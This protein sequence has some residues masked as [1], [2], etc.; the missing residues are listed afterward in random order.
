MHSRKQLANVIDEII[1]SEKEQLEEVEGT[2]V[3]D[4]KRLNDKCD[5]TIV[6]FKNRKGKKKKTTQQSSGE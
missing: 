3:E 1:T 6:K 5:A 2:I 4:Y